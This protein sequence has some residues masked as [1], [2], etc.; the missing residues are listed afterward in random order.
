M[1]PYSIC[2]CV[3]S[4]FHSASCS[5]GTSIIAYVGDSIVC[6]CHVLFIHSSTDGYLSCFLL[7]VVNNAAMHVGV[8]IYFLDTLSVIWGICP[9]MKLMDHIVI[10]F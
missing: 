10:I 9:E 3:T 8:Q 1:E 7:A 2:P 4:L 5:Q 6:V